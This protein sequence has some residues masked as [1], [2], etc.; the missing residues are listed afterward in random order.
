MPPGCVVGHRVRL[1]SPCKNFL[2]KT[3]NHIVFIGL[4]A[5]VY[6][7][8]QRPGWQKISFIFFMPLKIAIQIV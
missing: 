2:D 7:K 5:I 1:F 4:S 6:Y 3:D 8:V